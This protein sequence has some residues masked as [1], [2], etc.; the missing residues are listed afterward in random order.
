M[1]Y[2]IKFDTLN[3][4]ELEYFLGWTMINLKEGNYSFST[5]FKGLLNEKLKRN[6]F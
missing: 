6:G 4:D 3:K 2:S 5:L 1:E